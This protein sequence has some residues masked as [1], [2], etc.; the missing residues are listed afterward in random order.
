[1]DGIFLYSKQIF[2]FF[3]SKTLNY[4][5]WCNDDIEKKDIFYIL[6]SMFYD[7]NDKCK[8]INLKEL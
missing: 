2:I 3:N 7:F 8:I 5:Y 6:S 4:Y 1:M